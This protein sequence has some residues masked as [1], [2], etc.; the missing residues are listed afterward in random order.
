MTV[1]TKRFKL[2]LGGVSTYNKINKVYNHETRDDRK[3]VI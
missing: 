2:P 1:G 3:T